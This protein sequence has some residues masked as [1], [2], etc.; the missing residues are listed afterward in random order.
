MTEMYQND[1]LQLEMTRLPPRNRPLEFFLNLIEKQ[2][3]KKKNSLKTLLCLIYCACVMALILFFG[4]K[5][6]WTHY[7]SIFLIHGF[8]GGSNQTDQPIILKF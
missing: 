8:H 3:L 1:N 4:T 2:N 7:G 6:K 5:P